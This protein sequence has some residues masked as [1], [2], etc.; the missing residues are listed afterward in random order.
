PLVRRENP[1]LD[2]RSFDLRS[3]S[4]AEPAFIAPLTRLVLSDR[5]ITLAQE[6]ERAGLAPTA[7]RLVKLA[8]KIYDR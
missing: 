2:A 6:A 5:L 4:A 7:H 1:M 8:L 3:C